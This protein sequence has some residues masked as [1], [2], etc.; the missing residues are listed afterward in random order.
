MYRV[1]VFPKKDAIKSGITI[2][3]ESISVD[4]ASVNR[5]CFDVEN[6][7]DFIKNVHTYV[8]YDEVD[9]ILI[10]DVK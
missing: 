3:G 6:T 9:Q 2:K 4:G 1:T 8:N 10:D 7:L 5:I